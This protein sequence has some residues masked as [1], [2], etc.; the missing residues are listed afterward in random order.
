MNTYEIVIRENHQ[1]AGVRGDTVA[2]VGLDGVAAQPR[3]Q[4]NLQGVNSFLLAAT[5]YVRPIGSR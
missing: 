1:F 3:E 2:S 4:E 5:K